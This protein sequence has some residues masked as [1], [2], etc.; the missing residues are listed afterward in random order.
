MRRDLLSISAALILFGVVVCCCAPAV[1]AANEKQSTEFAIVGLFSPDRE[2]DLRDVMADIPEFQL[3]RVDYDNARATF[4]YEAA[5][6]FPERKLKNAPTPAEI[7]QRI[8][9]L[10]TRASTNTFSLKLTPAVP[11]EK[12][13]RIELNVGILDCKGCQYAAYLAAMKAPGVE[14]ATV[15]RD[16][17][18]VAMVETGKTDDNAIKAALK[19]ANIECRP[20]P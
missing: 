17:S 20:K 9:A 15:A 4:R 8:N 19:K 3:V 10:L 14:R 1:L 11:K 16:G 18:L 13:T 6:L 7:Q 12:L 2:Q 5:A